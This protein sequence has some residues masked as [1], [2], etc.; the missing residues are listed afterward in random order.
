[1]PTQESSVGASNLEPHIISSP[2]ETAQ[3]SMDVPPA[4]CQSMQVGLNAGVRA[5]GASDLPM[6]VQDGSSAPTQ[7]CS[8]GRSGQEDCMTSSPEAA[9]QCAVGI[10]P[11]VDQGGQCNA[12]ADCRPI[13]RS[14]TPTSLQNRSSTPPQDRS[15]WSHG[16]EACILSTPKAAGQS[17]ALKHSAPVQTSQLN[18]VAVAEGGTVRLS[19]SS[20]PIH[21]RS[22]LLATGRS[23]QDSDKAVAI[24][25][26]SAGMRLDMFHCICQKLEEEKKITS[27]PCHSV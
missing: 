25:S 13:Q 19:E 15:S 14:E 21:A 10:S 27:V 20:T 11:A 7:N 12:S 23:P 1:M 26:S 17:P 4:V 6:S 9:G 8:I 16:Q 2:Q 22:G 24:P 18:A 3:D 5:I